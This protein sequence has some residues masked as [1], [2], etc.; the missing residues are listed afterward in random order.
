MG[1]G[2]RICLVTNEFAGIDINGGVGTYY[3]ELSILLSKS[4]WDVVV[5]YQSWNSVDVSSGLSIEK[6]IENF[7]RLFYEEHG[8]KIFDAVKLFREIDDKNLI[9]ECIR[10][11]KGNNYYLP[12]SH[13]FHEALQ[14]LLNK[15]KI[16]FSLIE[17]S[18]WGG[19]GFIPI[20]MGK[21]FKDYAKSRLIVKLHSP[22]LWIN[23][24]HLY[25]SSTLH[26]FEIDYM[27]R[28]SFEN[29]DIQVS[30]T[31][32]LLMWCKNRGWN[33]R[34]DASICRYPIN[35]S[36]KY[37]HPNDLDK[38]TNIVFFG[39][40]E[41]RK[42]IKEFIEALNY[43]KSI[44]P[45]FPENFFITFLGKES[46]IPIDFI[47]NE[48]CGF[49]CIFKKLGQ[50]E[51][52]KYL[53]ESA[54]L[55]VLP[56]LQDNYPN[57][58][59]ECMS[60]GIPFIT[61]KGGGISEI[62][63]E[64]SLLYSSIACDP[65]DTEIFGSLILRFLNFKEKEVQK[66]LDLA[67]NRVIKLSDPD[68]IINWYEGKLTESDNLENVSEDEESELPW[69]TVLIPTLD[70]TTSNHLG[71]T[72]QSLVNQT[73]GHIK[74]IIN[75]ASDGPMAILE[76]NRLKKEYE[77][78]SNVKFVHQ[79]HKGIGNA[80]NQILPF[81]D[82]KYVMEVDADNIAIPEMVQT[83]VTCMEN[84]EDVAA[85]SCYNLFF[86]SKDEKL[87]IENMKNKGEKFPAISHSWVST[88][89]GPCL[90]NLFFS[91]TVGD[92][93]SIFSTKIV[94]AVGGW[95]DDRRG[96][97]DWAMWLKLI[98][99]G[100]NIDVIPKFLYYYRDEPGSDAKNKVLLW[101]DETNIEYIKIL[102]RNRPEIFN[103][104]CYES[105]HRLVRYSYAQDWMI[106]P[107]PSS[108]EVDGAERSSAIRDLNI[109]KSSTLY[110]LGLRLGNVASRSKTMDK[111]F[112]FSG[113]YLK[114]ILK[115]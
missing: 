25:A 78:W 81:V 105:L 99:Y 6:D 13:I 61:S 21:N 54:R 8:I 113:N 29:A 14:I 46:N 114:R 9:L 34:G 92:A 10:N 96:F 82:T 110:A 20:R 17:F 107:G 55:V 91:N 65:R 33:V 45:T 62:L 89:I 77:S 36:V 104:Y 39:R 18:E 3:R 48:L 97:Q 67:R 22:D 7:S 53:M 115:Y 1:K 24:S 94:K 75:D 112:K 103:S 80:L 69:V 63:G 16:D 12:R 43:I 41:E 56:S 23:E 15:Y 87:I 64:E 66:L 32:Y 70:R 51:G 57:T 26:D 49:H 50:D 60:A 58:I 59:L 27:N 73:Y 109:I 11:I 68:E 28:Y 101:V 108:K 47:K 79:V 102:I 83:C 30:P 85:L 74:I 5:L 42:G 98:A 52:I 95:P 86:F 88:P 84:R 2:K 106:N 111:F 100:Y 76:Y 93:N 4:G 90:P 37:K 31:Q 19:G 38:R 44:S 35:L 72:L 40:L 71:K